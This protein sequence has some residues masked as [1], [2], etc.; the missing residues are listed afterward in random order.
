[1]WILY[2]RTN[3]TVSGYKKFSSSQG[4]MGTSLKDYDYFGASVAGLGDLDGS[5][6]SVSAM[7]VGATGI[8]D[9]GSLAGGVWILRLTASET[10]YA[11]QK[12][13]N[14]AGGLGNVLSP[15]DEFGVGI[16]NL[17]DLD[18]DGV[19]DIAVGARGD[20]DAGADKGA[21]WILFLNIDGTVKA[22]QKISDTQGG[23]TGTFYVNEYF[24]ASVASRDLNGDGIS[25]LAVGANRDRDGADRAGAT[26]LLYL[27]TNGTVMTHR[28]ISATAGGFGG[29]LDGNDHFGFSVA[30]LDDLDGDGRDDLMA[31]APSDDD[32]GDLRGSVWAMMGDMDLSASATWRNPDIGGHTN[33]DVYSVV[34]LPILGQT[35]TASVDTGS[36]TK[37]C[38]LAGYDNPSA[39]PTTWGNLLVDIGGP[40]LLGTPMATGNPSVIDIPLVPDVSLIE[41]PVATQAI[42]FGGGNL[43]LTN[44]QDLVL[45]Y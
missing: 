27:N 45:G 14:T 23:F 40:E 6:G 8:D 20:D 16:A 3:G 18:G 22:K 28:K 11:K 43:E 2:L 32:G 4:G 10:L 42:I 37:G 15:A 29:T 24:G 5:G 34:G 39:L 21:V 26:W 13:S 41:V 1:V 44:A 31:G 7:A 9:G 38:F 17:G 25:D 30:I 19:T 33:P 12:I 36:P 35:F